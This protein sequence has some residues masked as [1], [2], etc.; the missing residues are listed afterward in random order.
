MG[1]LRDQFYQFIGVAVPKE[2]QVRAQQLLDAV[3]FKDE[4]KTVATSSGTG[5]PGSPPGPWNVGN[6]SVDRVYDATA[7]TIDEL[8]N[9]IATLIS[10]LRSRGVIA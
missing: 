3:A 2:H 7:T 8:A 10:D 6:A 4:L 9:V 1:K 5:L